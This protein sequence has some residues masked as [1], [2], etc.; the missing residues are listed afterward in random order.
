[1]DKYVIT[2]LVGEGSFGKVYKGRR[3]YTGRAVALKFIVKLGKKEKDLKALQSE[4]K[5]LQKLRHPNIIQM[6]DVFETK[7]EIC[8][9]TELAQGELF[10]VL[11]D[12]KQLP[13]K[14]V[15]NIGRQ[16]VKALDYL[17]SHRIIHR[18]IKPQNVLFCSNGRVALCDFGFARLMSQHTTMLTSIKGTPLYMAPELVKEQPYNHAADL[19]SLGVILYELRVGKPPFFTSH[20]YQLIQMIV[21]DEIE[22]PESEISPLMRSFLQ[23]LLVKD[24]AKRATWTQVR[25]HPW[26]QEP[27]QS[28]RPAPKGGDGNDAQYHHNFEEERPMTAPPNSSYWRAAQEQS[29]DPNQALA[30]RQ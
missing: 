15:Q 4:V 23:I 17:H 16:I 5:I 1:M 3:K 29:Q 14:V 30:L 28:C 6:L 22:Y 18:D 27:S 25:T 12:D 13:E 8:V 2:E 26:I 19:W 7:N 20:L 10:D 24:P 11:E 21:S 9:V